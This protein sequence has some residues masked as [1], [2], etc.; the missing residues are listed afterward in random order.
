MAHDNCTDYDVQLVGGATA[1]EG[2]VLMCLNGV[3]GTLCDQAFNATDAQV[4][5]HQA[6]YSGGISCLHS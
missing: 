6:G 4:V 2:K 3:W 1:N 5:C